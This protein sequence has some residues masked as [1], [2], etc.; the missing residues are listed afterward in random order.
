VIGLVT[1]S[2][3]QLPPQ[4]AER[5]GIRVVPLTVTVDGTDY[6]E[7][8]TLDADAFY[9]LFAHGAPVVKTSQ[10]SPGR[11]V[12]AYQ[13]LARRGADEILSVHVGS[14]I[15]GTI[16]SARLAAAAAPVR[17]RVVD[18]GTVSFGVACCV[19]E[20]A[21]TLARGG[22]LADA[23]EVAAGIGPTVG[24]VFVVKALDLARAGGRLAGPGRPTG[25]K[26]AIRVL[27][28]IG[29]TMEVIGTAGSDEEAAEVMAAHVRAAG[30]SLRA[31]IGS[32]DRA[33]TTALTDALDSRLRE[34]PEIRDVVRYRVGP[35]VGAH[36]GPGTVGA[37]YYES[38]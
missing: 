21:E 25:E 7:G 9:D 6:L 31:G 10:P 16:N 24:N 14:K 37:M 8:D 33:T 23:A 13:A 27:T 29:D 2:N 5:Y 15:S 11:F 26:A 36:T 19:W 35:S 20:A 38:S 34:A 1:D 12:D 22:T 30:S 3:S 4:L 32:A 18:T 17:V 28:F